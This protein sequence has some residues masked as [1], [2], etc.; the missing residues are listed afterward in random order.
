MFF[1]SSVQFSK[2]LFTLTLGFTR[3]LSIQGE[4]RVIWTVF[5]L[6]FYWWREINKQIIHF[7]NTEDSVAQF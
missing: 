3:V 5:E 7:S 1:F 6:S 2:Y 4:L